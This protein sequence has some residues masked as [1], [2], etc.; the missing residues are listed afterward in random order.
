M[1]RF[2]PPQD[3][4]SSATLARGYQLAEDEALEYAAGYANWV[5]SECEESFAPIRVWEYEPEELPDVLRSAT[6]AQLV[7]V[8][9]T[10][11][12]AEALMALRVLQERFARQA[13]AHLVGVV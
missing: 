3:G 9:N 2:L 4:P 11:C 5:A 8:Q 10:S 13:I 12:D 6:V 7:H 1:D